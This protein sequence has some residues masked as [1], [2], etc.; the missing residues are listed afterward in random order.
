[1]VLLIL[2][3]VDEQT[4]QTKAMLPAAAI[5]ITLVIIME[6]EE[7]YVSFDVLST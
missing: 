7:E 4:F 3:C 1:V 6:E 5:R 2:F